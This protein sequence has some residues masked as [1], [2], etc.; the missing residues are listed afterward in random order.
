MRGVRSVVA[1]SEEA[2]MQTYRN[3]GVEANPIRL[4]EVDGF[5]QLNEVDPAF[6]SSP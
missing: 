6:M 1:E 5:Q 2:C 3:L 4:F